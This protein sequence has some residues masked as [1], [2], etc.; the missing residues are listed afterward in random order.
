MTNQRFEPL[1]T[2][3]S[4]KNNFI[5]YKCNLCPTESYVSVPSISIVPWL[6][7]HISKWHNENLE[8]FEIIVRNIESM[9]ENTLM[10]QNVVHEQ[11]N[12]VENEPFKAQE[13]NKATALSMQL[14]LPPIY[15]DKYGQ[16]TTHKNEK[17]NEPVQP[18]SSIQS[19]TNNI[20]DTYNEK[21]QLMSTLIKPGLTVSKTQPNHGSKLSK[22]STENV[23][24]KPAF[25]K[26][27]TERKKSVH[28]KK[29][30]NGNVTCHRCLKTLK[31]DFELNRHIEE[32]HNKK[33]LFKCTEC[34]QTFGQLGNFETHM[35]QHSDNDGS[36][37]SKS[38]KENITEPSINTC[39]LCH[40]TFKSPYILNHHVDVV[41]NKKLLFNCTIC[42]KKFGAKGNLNNHIK[43]RHDNEGSKLST[44]SKENI[45]EKLYACKMCNKS[46]D[47]HSYLKRH[48]ESAHEGKVYECKIC[49]KTFSSEQSL[50]KHTERVHEGK[51][52][53]WICSICGA[54]FFDKCVMDVHIKGVHEGQKPVRTHKNDIENVTCD[55]CHKTFKWPYVLKQHVR[56]VHNKDLPF[57]CTIC[58]KKFGEKGSLNRHIKVV[59][60][61]ELLFKCT[62]CDQN[63][64]QL[65]QLKI[66]IKRHHDKDCSKLSTKPKENITE[67][68]TIEKVTSERKGSV[69]EKKNDNENQTIEDPDQNKINIEVEND[70]ILDAIELKEEVIEVKEEVIESDENEND[71]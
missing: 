7:K 15:I 52:K 1:F 20:P 63:F 43:R 62:K 4:K 44:S 21:R 2:F 49:N 42:G 54:K 59:H 12:I 41:H 45:T 48:T 70:E 33:V 39:D 14:K 17:S 31:S 9:A 64:G 6:K 68:S 8:K 35:K 53:N 65:F 26:V 60:K 5:Y 36:N 19:Q 11:E 27:T 29:N 30:H 71:S 69:H 50:K 22:H 38:P 28:E 51:E 34:G 55:L 66:H 58:E 57:N 61:K 13:L 25:E 47:F 24:E 16:L 37:L 46:F 40:K 18:V 10:E 3:D 67:K 32:V 23:T 56:T